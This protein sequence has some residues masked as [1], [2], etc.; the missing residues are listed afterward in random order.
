MTFKKNGSVQQQLTVP[1]LSIIEI[2]YPS[3]DELKK[4][5]MVTSPL[6]LQ[7]NKNK[8]ENKQLAMMRDELLPL[9]MNS[10]VVVN[11]DLSYIYGVL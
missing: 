7:I 5:D 4:Y 3:K 6:I 1:E 2:P 10:Q 9:L 11:S 8:K